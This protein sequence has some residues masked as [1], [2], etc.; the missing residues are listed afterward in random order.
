MGCLIP[1]LVSSPKNGLTF[2]FPDIVVAGHKKV[3]HY[4]KFLFQHVGLDP[5][6]PNGAK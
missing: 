6:K 2:E 1:S 5:T 4:I 3:R